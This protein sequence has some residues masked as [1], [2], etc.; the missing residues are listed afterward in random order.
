[1][2]Q[3]VHDPV[4]RL[5]AFP[6]EFMQRH[7]CWTS[8]C[9]H[10]RTV[11]FVVKCRVTE[12]HNATLS[13]ASHDETSAVDTC[14]P[15]SSAVPHPGASAEQKQLTHSF[16]K[17]H[18]Q[19]LFTPKKWDQI[20]NTC[21]GDNTRVLPALLTLESCERFLGK[22]QE[23]RRADRNRSRGQPVGHKSP[24]APQANYIPPLFH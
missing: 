7:D 22:H 2:A 17:L 6:Q 13:H 10:R 23:G 20:P 16:P 12:D 1:M 4:R 8:R 15:A 19:A 24:S 9:K 18:F 5:T 14:S 21:R 3:T 11:F